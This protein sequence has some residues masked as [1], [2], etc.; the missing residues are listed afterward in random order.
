[1]VPNDGITSAI[2]YGL[3]VVGSGLRLSLKRLGRDLYIVIFTI[4]C[5]VI[6]NKS[7]SNEDC[8]IVA[9]L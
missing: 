3:G 9:V 2:L 7:H 4:W 8:G 5:I 6:I 1:M